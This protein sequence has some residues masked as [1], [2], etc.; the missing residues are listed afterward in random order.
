MT[1]ARLSALPDPPDRAVSLPAVV[2]AVLRALATGALPSNSAQLPECVSGPPLLDVEET[3]ALLR[4]SR[5]TI[6]RMVD[7]GRLPSVIVR[8]GRVQKTRRIP[9]AFV[10][11]MIASACEGQQVDLAEY[12][13]AWLADNA[14]Q[15]RTSRSSPLG[16]A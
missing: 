8:H 6:T 2:E 12:A 4:V 11:Q 9:R 3:A 16:T 14:D 10:E 5:M 15:F 7:E 13:A 1:E